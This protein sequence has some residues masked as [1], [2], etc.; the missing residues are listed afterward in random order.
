MCPLQGPE[1]FPE[2]CELKA[3]SQDKRSSQGC[4]EL[5]NTSR[6]WSDCSERTG[7]QVPGGG[8]NFTKSLRCLEK[9]NLGGPAGSPTIPTPQLTEASHLGTAIGQPLLAVA[10]EATGTSAGDQK[11]RVARTLT[12]KP[13]P[14]ILLCSNSSP[15][16]VRRGLTSQGQ[17]DQTPQN[18]CPGALSTLWLWDW[19]L[20]LL[21]PLLLLRKE[22]RVSVASPPTSDPAPHP[23]PHLP[24]CVCV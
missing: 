19:E 10:V 8:E 23:R 22:G 16:I 9:S 21:P 13:S 3:K 24:T 14:H 15:M 1:E 4:T 12:K 5:S 20:G 7:S 2:S 18:H 6:V 17:G 11:D